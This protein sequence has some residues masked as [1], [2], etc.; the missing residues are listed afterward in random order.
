MGALICWGLYLICGGRC[1]IAWLY[2]S[3]AGSDILVMARDL[4]SLGVVWIYGGRILGRI[5]I[6]QNMGIWISG[7]GIVV[8]GMI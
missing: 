6:Q 1:S 3:A 2:I 4:I 7:G 8:A 5:L